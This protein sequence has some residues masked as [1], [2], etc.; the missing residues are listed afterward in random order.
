MEEQMKKG[1]L[2]LISVDHYIGCAH[3]ETKRCWWRNCASTDVTETFI[4]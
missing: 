2:P 1:D 4:H 3:V